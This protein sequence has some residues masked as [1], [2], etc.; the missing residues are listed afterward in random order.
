MSLDRR[1]NRLR[2][3]RHPQ[4]RSLTTD[5]TD[6]MADERT[7]L[8]EWSDESGLEVSF[9]LADREFAEEMAFVGQGENATSWIIYR[10][11]RYLWLC[12]IEDRARQGCEGSKEA[13]ESVEEALARITIGTEA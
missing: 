10:A 3:C 1:G 4:S 6:F 13:V 12:R 11:D 7:Y 8:A 2:H 9:K 5:R